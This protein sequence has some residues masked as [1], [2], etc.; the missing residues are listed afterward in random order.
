MPAQASLYRPQDI[1]VAKNAELGPKA[2]GG[3]CRVL[4]G[5][6]YGHR[7]P[8]P[9]PVEGGLLYLHI[10]LPTDTSTTLTIPADF[11]GFVYVMQGTAAVEGT[12][13]EERHTAVLSNSKKEC[14]LS[15]AYTNGG[16]DKGEV[17]MIVCAGKPQ[18]AGKMIKLLGNGGAVFA[19]S[20]EE[21]RAIMARYE[22]NPKNFGTVSGLAESN[23]KS[24]I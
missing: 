22:A 17:Q 2:I 23:N 5:E 16:S 19:T 7:S 24:S 20:E 6:Q 21:V 4:V 15:V 8:V 9:S 18:Q 14:Q 3:Q 10:Q 1:P 13:V 12:V 11:Q